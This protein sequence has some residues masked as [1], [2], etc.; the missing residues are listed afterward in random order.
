MTKQKIRKTLE[1][2]GLLLFSNNQ[3]LFSG[4]DA[5]YIIAYANSYTIVTT[6]DSLQE[7]A[8][9]ARY[10]QHAYRDEYGALWM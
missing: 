10:A 3:T 8:D 1:N 2:K 9:F 5:K 7:A 4:V 6:C